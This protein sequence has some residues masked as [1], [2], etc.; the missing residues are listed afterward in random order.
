[1]FFAAAFGYLALLLAGAAL[2][3]ASR[4]DIG[5]EICIALAC[6]A[7]PLLFVMA[8]A[9][10]SRQGRLDALR[11]PFDEADDAGERFAGLPRY[12]PLSSREITSWPPS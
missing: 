7:P 1:M 2:T 11:R 3:L 4:V 6:L 5:V 9:I 12:R 10:H 8:M